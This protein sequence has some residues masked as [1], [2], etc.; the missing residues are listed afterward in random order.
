MLTHA[1]QEWSVSK[2]QISTSLDGETVI[3]DT[4][5]G[6]YFSLDRVGSTLWEA[7]RQPRSPEAL[8]SLMLE[9]Y[10]V[11]PETAER[12]LKNLLSSLQEPGL[13]ERS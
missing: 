11:D 9:H 5:S 3:L 8:L 10:E 12:D 7:M 6:R 4:A 2:T 13:L 1:A